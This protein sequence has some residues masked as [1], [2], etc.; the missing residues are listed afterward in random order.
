[1]QNT[2]NQPPKES[3]WAEAGR[4]LFH[5]VKHNWGFKLLAVL[6]AII[7][8][9]GLIT[10]DP[11]LTRE[12]AFDDV[13]I[14]IAGADTIKRN[15]F[16]V[17]SDLESLLGNA[18]LRVAVPQMQYN[19]V[20]ASTFNTRVDLSRITDTGTQELK[21]LTTNSIAYG[22]VI[23]V[24]PAS[25][26]IEVEE[27]ITR[28]R[29]PVNVNATGAAPEGYYAGTAQ[30][31]PPMV[32]VSGP[33]SLV[34]KIVQAE[35]V[36]VLDELPQREGTIRRATAL[37]LLDEAGNRVESSLLSVTSESVL[38]DSVVVEQPLYTEKTL[39]LSDLGLVSGTPANGYEV[40]SV[41]YTPN[42]IRA[43]GRAINLDLVDTLYA[44]ASV[45]VS[46][47]TETFQ[48][49]VRVRRPTEILY[50]SADSVTVEVEIG[51]VIQDKSFKNQKINLQ[52]VDKG[53]LA[54]MNV[55]KA[56]VTITG[57][58]LWVK[59]LGNYHI[60]LTCDAAGLTAGTYDLPLG[61][62]IQNADGQSYTV[63]L[64]PATVQLTLT[65][66]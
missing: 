10:Q 23:E 21:V 19:S 66:K 53:L 16:I 20:T 27:Y 45:D 13:K 58:Q 7:M 11:S 54:E 43:A 36:L 64:Q 47:K 57:P 5:I 8:W 29:I 62:V 61:C 3:K 9:S 24:S 26:Q 56:D 65:E 2:P 17:V 15:G 31:D 30:P 25:V 4:M 6:L 51:P 44:N 14:A 28:Y 38:L 34:E 42:V 39:Q 12:K 33:K 55:R 18:Q 37:Y 46:G 52:N 60:T 35:A 41:T 49:Q 50:L 48:Q 40:K 1:M 22:N 32:A 59:G 63:D